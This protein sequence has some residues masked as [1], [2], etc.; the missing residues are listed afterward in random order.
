MLDTAYSDLSRGLNEKQEVD[1]IL[2]DFSKAFDKVP[3]QRILLKLQHYGV[4]GN[5]LEWIKYFF[6]ARTQE[7][8]IDGT[9]S[10]P[11]SVSSAVP[12][13][14]V[15]GPLPYLAYINDMPEGIQS[16][17][18]LFAD[19]SL[20]YRKI[21]S[22]RDCVELQQDRER[23]QEWEKKWQMAFNAEKCEILC[24]S[25]KKHPFQHIYFIHDQKLATKTDSK[26]L[27]VTI[28]SNLS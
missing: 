19:Y 5:L 14:T 25:N 2:L 12:H 7:V 22:N 9:M 21:S 11:S 13:G 24:I 3:H 17:V 8:V 27:G 18:K 28:R 1:A 10:T 15:L 23:L 4:Y 20:L 16:T 26:Y 6:S